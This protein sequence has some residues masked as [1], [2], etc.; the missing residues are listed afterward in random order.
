MGQVKGQHDKM[1]GRKQTLSTVRAR[2]TARRN[3]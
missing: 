1:A 2:E 3:I